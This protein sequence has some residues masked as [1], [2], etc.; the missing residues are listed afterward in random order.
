MAIEAVG[1]SG[2]RAG[3]VAIVRIGPRGAAIDA[4]WPEAGPAGPG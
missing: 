1:L 4:V 3:A 2:A